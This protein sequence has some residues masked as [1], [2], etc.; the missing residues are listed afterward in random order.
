M[1]TG[2]NSMD[3]SADSRTLVATPCREKDI[4]KSSIAASINSALNGCKYDEKSRKS[5]SP[6]SP[7]ED[8]CENTFFKPPENWKQNRHMDKPA[9]TVPRDRQWVND[10]NSNIT[11]QP[12]SRIDL[13]PSS[14][15]SRSNGTLQS[16]P[17]LAPRARKEVAPDY[18]V[19]YKHFD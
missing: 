4:R 3:A 17:M 10:R 11:S 18:S 1:D 19:R 16:S 6:V 14:G 8:G 9:V 5:K 12:F 13:A 2:Y 15:E 7:Q